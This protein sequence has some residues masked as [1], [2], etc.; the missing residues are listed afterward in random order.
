MKEYPGGWEEKSLTP[1]SS[2]KFYRRAPDIFRVGGI[3][4]PYGSDKFDAPAPK[5][6][7]GANF[8]IFN[9]FAEGT[10]KGAHFLG[11]CRRYRSTFCAKGRRHSS[12]LPL[13]GS[14]LDVAP[15]GC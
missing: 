15:G 11:I 1:S 14:F 7:G 9:K 8:Q 4:V 5:G 3:E 10:K 13:G 2:P 6:W 12:H